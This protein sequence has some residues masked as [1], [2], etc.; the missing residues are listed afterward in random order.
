[1]F[2]SGVWAGSAIGVY[3]TLVFLNAVALRGGPGQF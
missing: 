2:G 3:V 1:M